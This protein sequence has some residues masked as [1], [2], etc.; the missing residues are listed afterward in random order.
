[1][2]E[3]HGIEAVRM[4]S[5]TPGDP[6]IVSNRERHPISKEDKDFLEV[7]VT[8]TEEDALVP[9]GDLIVWCDQMASNLIVTLLE[10]QSQWGLAPLPEFASLLTPWVRLPHQTNREGSGLTG[11]ARRGLS[12]PPYA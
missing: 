7:E 11:E 3:R 2:L 12:I 6:G 4:E 8:V 10:P 5:P 1:M 9:A